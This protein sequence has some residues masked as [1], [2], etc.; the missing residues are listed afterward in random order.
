[1]V[2]EG[3]EGLTIDGKFP[4]LEWLGGWAD[5]CVFLTVGQSTHTANIKLIQASGADAESCVAR[6]EEAKALQHPRLL[7]MMETG[8][9]RLN[10]TDV[11]YVVTEKAD[12]FLSAIVPRTA[13]DSAKVHE[14]LSPVVDAL[15]FVHQNGFVHGSLKP[16]SVVLIGHKWKLSPDEISRPGEQGRLT[17]ELD[18]Y[19]APEVGVGTQTAAA[20]MWSL[21]M[22]VVEAC[23]QRTPVWDRNAVADLGVPDWLPEP[24][25]EIARG[26]LRWDPGA[27]ISSAQ[28]KELLARMP[29]N[30]SASS[31]EVK[32]HSEA[33]RIAEE[34]AVVAA[35]ATSTL[36]ERV[37][38]VRRAGTVEELPSRLAERKT[39]EERDELTP[40]SRL[41]ANLDEE[42]DE[43]SSK[44]PMIFGILVLLVIGVVLGV[45]Y[46]DR[47]WPL[48]AKQNAPVVSQ[49]SPQAE[50]IPHETSPA[51][52]GEAESKGQPQA[53]P[54]EIRDAGSG[55]P[56][57]QSSSAPPTQTPATPS[58][59]KVETQVPA[60][61]PQVDE[62]PLP[63]AAKEK[64]QPREE[65]RVMNA[66]GAVLKR[67]L[68]NVAP[69]AVQSMRRPVQVDVRVSVRQNGTVAS[70][71]SM[72]QG[73]GNYFA[74]IS[75]Q[76]AQSW[77]FKPPIS[78]GQAR[79]SEWMLLFRFDRRHSD[80]IATQL[81]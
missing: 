78:A 35:Q 25:R 14:I 5:R 45:R 63:G 81:H 43:K 70:A 51:N 33:P 77:T 60:T 20:D 56:G 68:P 36:S 17:R 69:G 41:F 54:A 40:R 26:C 37:A 55:E 24:F 32:R 49:S 39:E 64:A 44:G 57:A 12:T 15:S 28:V 3:W 11:A 79:E 34:S 47:L 1:M 67:V 50:S 66:K 23:S 4:L 10:E 76:A 38:D 65:A 13:L 62:R 73:T 16:S 22:I 6:W 29:E 48:I 71:Q 2:C 21:G 7:E 46:R 59:P 72:T 18:T 74:R 80:V 31:Y 30:E 61:A 27:R 19:D 75:R 58:Q 8:R 53:P 52:A 9:Y 42:E